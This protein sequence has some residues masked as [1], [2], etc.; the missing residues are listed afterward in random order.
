MA[1]KIE[2]SPT[3][4]R[5]VSGFQVEPGRAGRERTKKENRRLLAPDLPDSA[6]SPELL[7]RLASQTFC[8]FQPFSL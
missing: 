4:G 6:S 8:G 7:G 1:H 3:V 5:P 2:A